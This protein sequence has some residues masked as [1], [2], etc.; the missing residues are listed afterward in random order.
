MTYA[1]LADRA[2]IENE[3]AWE[4]RDV[5]VNTWQ[6]LCGTAAR[7]GAH[8][9]VTFQM[10]SGPGDK[11]ETLTWSELQDRTAQA[12]NMFRALGVGENDVVAYVLPNCTETVL[13][14]LGAQIAG[15]VNPINPLLEPEQIGAI[16]R[17]T[18]AKVVVTLRASPRLMWRRRSPRRWNLP[19]TWKP[20]SRS[21]CCA[22][23]PAR[24][25]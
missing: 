22:I 5:P 13:T 25:S 15:I 4:D 8:A 7:Y 12:A 2:A 17:E 10:F 19:R 23:S 1:T 6:L 16:L 18:N 21:T 11:A 14:Y 9:A 20:C 24:K 3:A